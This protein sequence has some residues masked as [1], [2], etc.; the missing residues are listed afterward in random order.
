MRSKLTLVAGAV[1]LAAVAVVLPGWAHRAHGNYAVETA[2]FA[3]VITEVHALNLLALY[4]KA[5]V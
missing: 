5:L 4:E 2:D 3:G 1:L